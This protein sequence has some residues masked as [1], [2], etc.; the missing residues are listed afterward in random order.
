MIHSPQEPARTESCVDPLR[1]I[2]E[3]RLNASSLSK[4]SFSLPLATMY[5]PDPIQTLIDSG[6]THC[7]LSSD[8]VN[9]YGLPTSDVTLKSLKLFDGSLGSTITKK[10]LLPIQFPSG[11]TL[12]IRFLVTPL[13]LSCSAVLGYNWLSRYN[14]LID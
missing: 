13:D 6:S 7:F 5:A 11:E 12:D 1:A 8:F 10:A 4:D 14:P 3:I 2:S 9:K